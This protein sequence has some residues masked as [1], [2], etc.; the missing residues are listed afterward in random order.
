MMTEQ[1][2]LVLAGS[3]F[4]IFWSPFVILGLSS[5]MLLRSL[6]PGL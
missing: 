3:Y 2:V 5:V 4:N 1:N 6:T